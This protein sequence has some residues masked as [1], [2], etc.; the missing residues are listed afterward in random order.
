MIKKVVL[1]LVLCSVLLG[2]GLWAGLTW[3]FGSGAEA[4]LADFDSSGGGDGDESEL[5]LQVTNDNYQ[6]GFLSSQAETHLG[7]PGDDEDGDGIPD[8]ALVLRH[9]IF[10]GP[11][12]VT[13]DGVIPCS[14]HIVTTID[15]DR[16]PEKAR[17][18]LR[19]VFGEVVPLTI[20][21]TTGM[22]RAATTSVEISPFA[23]EDAESGGRF[24]YD[25]LKADFRILA[26]EDSL[27]SLVGD[28]TLGGWKITSETGKFS[29]APGK[30]SV[31]FQDERLLKGQVTLGEVSGTGATLSGRLGEVSLTFD[32]EKVGEV[33]PLFLGDSRLAFENLELSFGGEDM[34]IR[35]GEILVKS[36]HNDDQVHGSVRYGVGGLVIPASLAGPMI[37]FLPAMEKGLAVELGGRGIDL[38]RLQSTIQKAQEMQEVQMSS[39]QQAMSGEA[40]NL[41]EMSEY[42]AAMREYLREFIGLLRPGAEMYQRLE[43][44]GRS[45][46][47]HAQVTLGMTGDR[48]LMEMATLRDIIGSLAGDA[49]IKVSKADLPPEQ[50]AGMAAGLAA[51]GFLRDT[52]TDIIGDAKLT[53]GILHLNGQPTPLIDALGPQLDEPISWDALLS[54]AAIGAGK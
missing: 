3:M 24:E 45:G 43:I 6:R 10:H 13:P 33:V 14:N 42:Q 31:D 19:E 38:E 27:E 4:A 20:R 1:T 22:N 51:A 25:G 52:P 41:E 5:F 30:A 16:L 49:S 34:M 11:L 9:Q 54:T 29:A 17:E 8:E 48:A 21:T 37:A 26:G 12:A 39:L 23:Y 7:V 32:Q 2:V 40:T 35:D 44:K 18:S 36:G 47:S 53:D 28:A 50:V 46:E 15:L